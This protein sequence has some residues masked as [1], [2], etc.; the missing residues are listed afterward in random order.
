[1]TSD[2]DELARTATALPSSP[3]T[4]PAAP[5]GATIGRYS[6]E[7][8]LGAGGMGVVHVAFDP[9]LE[10]RV[11]LKVLRGATGAD[12][13]KRLQREA[14]AMARLNHPNVVTVHE[15]GSVAGRDYVAMELIDGESLAEWLRTNEHAPHEIIQAFLA[16]GRGLAAAH[17]AG[18]VHRDFKP[19]NVLRSNDGRVCVTDFGLAREASAAEAKAPAAAGEPSS[20]SGLTVSGS[21]LGTPAYMAPEQWEGGEVTPATDQFG[22]CV[23]LWEALAGER[24]Y[25]GATAAELRTQVTEG[26]RVLDA[27]GIPRRV[28]PILRR[29]LDPD[30][31]KRWRNMDE[32][33]QQLARAERKPWIVF[34]AAGASLIAAGVLVFVLSGHSSEP[35]CAAP[36][37]DPARVW[38]EDAALAAIAAKQEPASKLLTA[39]HRRWI[40]VRGGACAAEPARRAAGLA[41]LDGVLARFD[42]IAR[43]AITPGAA[44]LDVGSGL[45]DPSVCELTPVPRLVAS[46]SP[47]MQEVISARLRDD[48]LENPVDDTTL[49]ALVE[50]ASADPCAEA[51]ADSYLA[52]STRLATTRERH[53]ELSEQ[54]ADRCGDDRIRAELAISAVGR[55]LRNGFV[56]VTLA[57]R[58]ARAQ[59]AVQRVTQPDLEAQI[60]LFRM[61]VDA[62]SDRIDRAITEGE[63]SAAGYA[64]RGRVAAQ[65]AVQLGALQIRQ[66]RA[67]PEDLAAI[68]SGLAALRT[69]AVAE[70]GR[71]HPILRSID[72]VHGGWEWAS[73]DVVAAHRRFD[74]MRRTQPIAG[75]VHITGTVVDEAGRPAAGVT[76][77][78]GKDFSGDSASVV[79]PFVDKPGTLR[80]ATTDAGGGFV[81]ADAVP[82]GIVIAQL[83]DKRSAPVVTA[84]AV[85]LVLAPTSKLSGKVE[86]HDVP[87]TKAVV[88]IVRHGEPREL[89]YAT[90]A[91]VRPDGTFVLAGAPRGEVDLEVIVEAITGSNLTV[92]KMQIDAPVIDNLAISVPVSRRTVNVL[93]RSTVGVAPGNAQVIVIPGTLAPTLT[94]KALVDQFGD[95][96]GFN[97][98]LA[99]PFDADAARLGVTGK[100]GDLVVTNIS[101]PD[102]AASACGVGLPA[103]IG[104]PSFAKA[105]QLHQ[106]RIELRCVP[107]TPGATVITVE[108]PPWP[109]FD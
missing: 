75:A 44:P 27:S 12:A 62:R 7:R 55:E 74:G 52:D 88:A 82:D 109:R 54:A 30:P 77:V 48:A 91:P 38:S 64:K 23:A 107:I 66:G 71:E 93:V 14:R 26:P 98:R 45:I 11:A 13:A 102:G 4:G 96:G 58:L 53:A 41:C 47:Q 32:L 56:G 50:R 18:I 79:L 95:L 90:V 89:R 103:D 70:L 49:A 51:L 6:L 73:G 100:P 105:L 86:L 36:L 69:R 81:I 80:W 101:V 39:D 25:R 19:H 29:G 16:A 59:V 60:S 106:D 35:A 28:R 63:A 42:A 83:G 68:S 46:P 3:A 85:R 24:P 20:L 33:L 65:I 43:T 61:H 57:S 108:V 67:R 31:G 84:H 37:L 1:M 87:S 21:V 10:R 2:P 22:Y 76:V 34:A 17:A 40:E 72:L 8:E 99:R 9:D 104:D 5:V 78:A 94:A 92:E 97:S 15:V